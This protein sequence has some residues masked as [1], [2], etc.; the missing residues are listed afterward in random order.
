MGTGEGQFRYPRGVALIQMGYGQSVSTP[1][2]RDSDGLEPD[3]PLDAARALDFGDDGASV[4]RGQR[5]RGHGGGSAAQ[6]PPRCCPLA[7]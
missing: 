6:P 3:S 1:R 7:S 4:R 2:A 5:T